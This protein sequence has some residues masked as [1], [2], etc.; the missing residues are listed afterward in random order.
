MLSWYTCFYPFTFNLYIILYSK[1]VS[2]TQHIIRSCFLIHSDS[3]PF[4]FSVPSILLLS[5]LTELLFFVFYLVQFPFGSS[6]C[7][8]FRLRLFI[9]PLIS[10]VFMIAAWS[11][12]IIATWRFL[13]DNCN[14]CVTAVFASV[15]YLF[16]GNWYFP[17]SSYAKEL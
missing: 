14:I 9:F 12:I 6:L 13:P 11:F 16:P 1:W 15:D 8:V 7:H 5:L 2:F 17:E 10:V 4:S 3:L